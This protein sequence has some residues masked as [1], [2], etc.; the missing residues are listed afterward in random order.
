MENKHL[1]VLTVFGVV[2]LASIA[3]ALWFKYQGRAYPWKASAATF[4]V[5]V[6]QRIIN[7]AMGAS[8]LSMMFWLSD[9]RLFTIEM[10]SAVAWLS[11]FLGVEFFY[12][13]HHRISHTNRFFWAT[14]SV[15][16]SPEQ[17]VLFGALRLGWTGSVTG[18]FLFYLPLVLLGFP[19]TAVFGVLVLN[20]LYQFWLHT[21]LIPKLGVFEWLF[22]TPSHHRVHHG[23]NPEYLDRNYGGTLIIFDRLF[24]TFVEEK[25][26]VT[27]RYGLVKPLQSNN[28]I[29]IALHEWQAIAKDLCKVRNAKELWHT[30]F[31]APG[32][33][34]DRDT[35]ANTNI[36]H[37]VTP[38]SKTTIERKINMKTIAISACALFVFVGLAQAQNSQVKPSPTQVQQMLAMLKTEMPKRFSRA[39]TNQDGKLTKSEANG[40][41]PRV[42]QYFDSIDVQKRGY[43][44]QEDIATYAHA[45][46]AALS[47]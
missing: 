27:I 34:A 26:D 44:T 8:V 45:Q 4:Q 30:L 9:F 20:L 21:E 46:A 41:M 11:L 1:I 47:K 15:H 19:P 7:T 33:Q 31:G 28:P 22:N 5:W 2:L 39:D 18:A 6:I 35:P 32:W 43:V 38:I 3:E 37:P 24:N 14:H 25:G 23:S 13:W 10:D 29:K 40:T 12:Y 42:Y 16:H 17:L 36:K